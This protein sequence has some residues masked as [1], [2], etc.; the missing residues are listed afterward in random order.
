M[1]VFNETGN[2][3][4]SSIN[5]EDRPG[6]EN[7]EYFNE[8]TVFFSAMTNV[9]SKTINPSTNKPYTP[10]SYFA[11][12][13]ILDDSGLFIPISCD[14]IDHSI[15]A[16]GMEFSQTMIKTILDL[17]NGKDPLPFAPSMINAI[18]NECFDLLKS[19]SDDKAANI[20][21]LCDYLSSLPIVISFVISIDPIR[22]RQ[23]LEL[24]PCKSKR[25]K[26]S[27]WNL[28]K[29]TYLFVT[30]EYIKKYT[31]VIKS[32]TGSANADFLN[33]LKAILD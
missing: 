29:E 33:H 3:M 2:I 15:N 21:F 30:P 20:F 18:G 28:T 9:L 11:I 12:K 24:I 27:N 31:N 26:L 16:T 14:Q 13:T 8:V 10:Y 6:I 22:N 17:H 25:P 1:V 32:I 19:K 5:M 7:V 4:V 23:S